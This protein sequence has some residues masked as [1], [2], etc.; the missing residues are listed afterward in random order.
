MPDLRRTLRRA[1]GAVTLSVAVAAVPGAAL[2]GTPADDLAWLNAKRAAHGIPGD[3]ALR[4]DWSEACAAHIAYMRETGSVSHEEDPSSRFFT[5]SGDW[6]GR[7]AVL[8]SAPTWTAANFIWGHAPLHLAQLMAPQLAEMG[9]ADDGQLVCAT[10]VPGYTRTAPPVPQTASYPGNGGSIHPS[11]VAEE[12]PTTPAEALGLPQP[13]G[14]NL[15]VYRWGAGTDDPGVRA[16][17]LDG[18]AGAVPARWIDRDHPAA[19]AYLPPGGAIIVPVAPLQP[20]ADYSAFVEFDDGGVHTWAFTTRTAPPARDIR[21]GALRAR[22]I[23]TARVCVDRGPAG[24]RRSERRDRVVVDLRGSVL[25]RQLG[26]APVAGAAVD[27]RRAT[28]VRHVRTGPDGAFA[29]RLTLLV[30]P[31]QRMVGVTVSVPGDAVRAW[32][33][34]IRRTP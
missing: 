17:R 27:V 1:A 25:D 7:N 6:A 24:C 13:T 29:A 11:E 9:I 14:P 10:T 30:R 12:L 3:I 20:D 23:G 16:V 8:A 19:G 26:L 21:R 22:R 2:A 28:A 4:A 15:L 5:A 31:G 18:P 34:R 32:P 33:V